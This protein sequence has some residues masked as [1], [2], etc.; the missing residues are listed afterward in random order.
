MAK[1]KITL[2]QE[3]CIGCGSCSVICPASFGFDSGKSKGTVKKKSISKITC[4][5]EAADA[6]PVNAI[7]IK[8]EK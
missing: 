2:N 6:C 7:E 8:E 5:K 3:E 1:Y 4:E